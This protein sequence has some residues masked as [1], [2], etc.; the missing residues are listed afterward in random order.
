MPQSN[1]AVQRFIGFANFYLGFI[2]KYVKVM[3][4]L[5]ELLRKTERVGTLK[6]PIRALGMPNQPLPEWE[7]T[8]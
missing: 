5:T 4:P 7:W 2:G 8:W 6:A 1:R 3:L